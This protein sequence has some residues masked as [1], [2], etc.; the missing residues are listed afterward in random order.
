MELQKMFYSPIA[1]LIL[2]IFAIQAGIVFTGLFGTV[3]NYK[4]LGY[5]T[6]ELTTKIFTGNNGFYKLI[7]SNIYLYL[8]LIT[9]GLLSKE[10]GSG[11][12]KL[13]YSS[14]ISNTQ[15]VLGKFLSMVFFGFAMTFILFLMGVYGCF[16]IKMYDFPL[17]LT[18]LL[19][20]FLLICTYSAIGLFMSSLTSY[21]VV[22]AMGSFAAFFVLNQI[23][24]MWQDI[25]FVR[26]ITYWLQLSG[27]SQPF[28]DG[29][30]CSEDVLYFI[31][32]SVLFI[33][34]TILKLKGIRERSL[35]YISA[36]RYA[37]TFGIVALL[38]YLTTI[39]SFMIYHDSTQTKLRTLT[40]N[41]Q[42]I[43]A[44]LDGKVKVTTYVNI[45]DR[46]FFYGAPNK[47]NED[48]ERFM[49]YIR[50]YPN[51]EFEYKYYY[52]V[53]QDKA[54]QKEFKRRFKDLTVEQAVYKACKT[55]KVD[56]KMFKPASDYADQIDL[57]A[58][59]GRFVRKIET[60]D[61][62]STILRIYD[63]MFVFPFESQKTAAFKHLVQE[64][65]LV[66]FVEGHSERELND[67]GSRGYYSMSQDKP[68]RNSLLNNG[69]DFMSFDLSQA[70]DKRV[71]ILIISGAKTAYN[72][73][74][75]K[76][77][78]DYIDR[79]GNVIF[80]CDRK[81]QSVM[82]PLV[83]RLGVQFMDGQVVEYNKGYTQEIV[84]ADLTTEGVAL[85]FPFD[86]IIE[87]KG[88]VAM[89]GT[90][91]IQYDK[92]SEFKATPLLVTDSIKNLPKRNDPEFLRQLELAKKEKGKKQLSETESMIIASVKGELDEEDPNEVKFIGSWNELQTTDF[93]DDVAIY[94]PELDEVAG[95]AAVALALERKVG[96]KDQR[97]VVLGDADVFSNGELSRFRKG[98]K[99]MNF[100]FAIGVYYW[101]SDNEVP[102]DVRRPD[103]PDNDIY[104][105]SF[106][107]ANIFYKYILTALLALAS[108]LIWLRRRGR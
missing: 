90:V 51:M 96:A 43:I 50:F 63:D 88:C 106:P 27:R 73:Q 67:F 49:R 97:I 98:I 103:H 66:G 40:E 108:L 89:N 6:A 70:V 85:S 107:F 87:K 16:T 80:A 68:M 69:F 18:G 77:L 38:G 81:R 82:N 10:F 21:Q 25:E 14:P 26:N 61:G 95:P 23:G 4:E 12:I 86:V 65:P 62:Q 76:H 55:Y 53:P 5:G 58:E 91:G 104:P 1:W 3:V 11:S 105:A 59:H 9:M 79:G 17:V 35:R 42:D 20:V 7:S 78:N 31:L 44:K 46:N 8:P 75:M 60:E 84:S 34:F 52:L 22:A 72:D 15:I 54:G 39:P 33:T 29:L 102:I 100:D 74:E 71:D 41:S 57:K 45:F 47:I 24:N 36:I 19:G 37:S 92:S 99:A 28:Y 13:L 48:R 64:L 101:L 93:E 83:E 94:N 2:I 56:P 30:I 32:V